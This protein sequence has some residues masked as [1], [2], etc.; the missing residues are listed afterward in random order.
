MFSSARRI[1]WITLTL[2]VMIPAVSSADER[3]FVMIFGSELKSKRPKYTHTWATWVKATGEG[4][5]LC[6]YQLECNTI[7]WMPATLD[8]RP[9]THKSEPGVNLDLHPTMKLMRS[10]DEDI[11]L[12]GPYEVYQSSWDRFVAQREYLESGNVRYLCVN[13]LSNDINDKGCIHAITDADPRRGHSAPSPGR[14]C[15]R[16]RIA[17]APPAQARTRGP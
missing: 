7:S 12:W 13:F 16:P 9:W 17:R 1:L 11:S 5:N 6:E 3:Y 8:I 14:S 10:F 2:F 15:S 4:P